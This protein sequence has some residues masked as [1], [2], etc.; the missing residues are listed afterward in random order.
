MPAPVVPFDTRFRPDSSIYYRYGAFE[1]LEIYNPDGTHTPAILDRD[2]KLMPDLRDSTTSPE[3]AVN[4]F[5]DRPHKSSR[6]PTESLLGTTFR[7]FQAVAQRGKGGI[8]VAL[9]LSVSPPR[10]CILKEGRRNGEVSWDGRDGYWRVKHEEQVLSS[11]RRAGLKVPAVYSSFE[12]KNNYY[13]VTEFIYGETLQASLLKK[14]RRLPVSRA[15][16]HG[17]QVS[18]LLSR[19]HASGW[20]WRD[21]K[22][23]NIILTKD[24]SL[25][26]L[27]FEG[28][29]PV[30]LP[31][32][33][34]WST[35]GFIPPNYNHREVSLSQRYDDLYALGAIIYFLLSGRLPDISPSAT[36]MERWRRGI[37]MEV[38]NLVEELLGADPLGRPEA[39]RVSQR[40]RAALS[41][42]VESTKI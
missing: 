30:N 21:C 10:L 25:R 27:D 35:Q 37:P 39:R 31:D 20:A 2:G 11:L 19:I 29:C 42:I 26:A 32:P 14:Q 23:T 38:C 24:G 12:E 16:R 9:D 15:L 22:P 13:L 5:P 4:P 6:A 7:A 3:W 34:F 18:M 8:Y 1:P 40:L 28:A 33:V 36:P 17:I 41:G